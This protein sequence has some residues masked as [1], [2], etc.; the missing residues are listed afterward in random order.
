VSSNNEVSLAGGSLVAIALERKAASCVWIWDEFLRHTPQSIKYRLGMELR[1]QTKVSGSS[2]KP[3]T[4]SLGIG[5]AADRESDYYDANVTSLVGLPSSPITTT[6]DG[7]LAS[8]THPVQGGQARTPIPSSRSESAGG[9]VGSPVARE[10]P[11]TSPGKNPG[12]RR[13]G[14]VSYARSAVP[15]SRS[16]RRRGP[17][18][19]RDEGSNLTHNNSL[20]VTRITENQ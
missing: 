8:H 2:A 16:S 1:S 10:E 5:I 15:S 13:R 6:G 11:A 14:R 9:A 12:T 3:R 18:V 19:G 17:S 7:K 20:I 4:T